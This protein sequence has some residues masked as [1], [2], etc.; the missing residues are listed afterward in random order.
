VSDHGLGRELSELSFG[1]AFQL[2]AGF[3]LGWVI[4]S[5]ILTPILLAL[6]LFIVLLVTGVWP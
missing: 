6:L 5:T 3:A 4:V 2:G 1:K